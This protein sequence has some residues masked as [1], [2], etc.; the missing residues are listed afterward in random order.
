MATRLWDFYYI[1]KASLTSYTV[2]VGTGN[3]K[4]KKEKA[5]GAKINEGGFNDFFYF[6]LILYFRF[7]VDKV[8]CF[9]HSESQLFN[10]LCIIWS[11]MPLVHCLWLQHSCVHIQLNGKFRRELLWDIYISKAKPQDTNCAVE[12]NLDQLWLS[13]VQPGLIT[14]PMLILRHVLLNAFAIKSQFQQH[15]NHL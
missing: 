5:Q 13:D 2:G 4:N 3:E 11:Y 6:L 8:V 15:T 1:C 14:S 12:D 9:F 7:Y 10:V